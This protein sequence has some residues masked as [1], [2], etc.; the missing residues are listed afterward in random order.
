MSSIAV[1]GE[2]ARVKHLLELF[3]SKSSPAAKCVVIFVHQFRFIHLAEFFCRAARFAELLS[4][5][6]DVELR[7]ADE[8]IGDEQVT[9]VAGE[10]SEVAN[11]M[12]LKSDVLFYKD[13]PVMLASNP[14]LLPE[15]ERKEIISKQRQQS[16]IDTD[17]FH[18]QR[19]TNLIHDKSLQQ[20]VCNGTGI[21][22]LQHED[23]FAMSRC[24]EIVKEVTEKG[25][26]VVA[27]MNAGSGGTG[28]KFFTPGQTEKEFETRLL[29]MGKS[30]CS[31][32]GENAMS[33]MYPVRFFEFAKSKE[34]VIADKGSFVGYAY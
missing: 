24:L 7:N 25:K 8:E 18:E 16:K 13:V 11:Y 1:N 15:L 32:Y 12:E 4:H 5:Y 27:K 9:V 14:N 26:V 29:D 33:T 22:P 17:I 23:A 20:D 34:L 3:L 2:E 28:I 19:C 6:R 10:I 31:K 21:E 30:V